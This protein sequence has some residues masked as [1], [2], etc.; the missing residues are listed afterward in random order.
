MGQGFFLVLKK[1][2]FV[3]L[4][5]WST[6]FYIKLLHKI[7]ILHCFHFDRCLQRV[8]WHCCYSLRAQ[9]Y[10]QNGHQSLGKTVC[11]KWCCND[12]SRTWSWT[13][14]S[15]D[16]DPWVGNDGARG[17]LFLKKKFVLKHFTNWLKMLIDW[18]WNKFGYHVGWVVAERGWGATKNGT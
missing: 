4:V 18:R 14:G 17:S 5:R 2:S 6:F 15:Q 11:Y 7:I 12:Y 1:R 10:E 13:S 3:I 16:D 9:R 8:F